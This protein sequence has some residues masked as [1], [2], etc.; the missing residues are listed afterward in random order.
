MDIRIREGTPADAE[1]CGRISYDAFKTI[2]EAHGF[3][4]YFQAPEVPIGLL[5]S[6]LANPKFYGVVAEIDGRVVGSNFLDERNLIAGVGPI[7]VDPA[8][9]NRAVGRRLMDAVHNRAA[10]K[11]FAGVRLIQAGFHTRSLALYAKLGYDVRE[12]LAYMQGN[13]L[14]LAVEGHVVRPAAEADIDACNCV[15]RQM[16]GHDRDGRLRE[17]IARGTATVVEHDG[18][19]TGYAT[20]VGFFGHAAGETNADVKALIGAAKEFAGPGFLLP[21]RNGELFRWCLTNGLQVTQP[22]TLMSKGLYN[23]PAGAFL[24][25]ILY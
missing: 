25:S 2:S 16:H 14:N 15:C 3:A 6:L 7:T 12:H 22:M 9:Q 18:R 19:I 11:N 1:I 10:A 24:P 8:V 23:E 17:A 5:T 20:I 21:T 13:A 4:P